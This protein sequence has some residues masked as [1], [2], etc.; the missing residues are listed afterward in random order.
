[1]TLKKISIRVRL[2]VL[3]ILTLIVCC[4]GLTIILNISANRMADVIE[5]TP[6]IPALE[7]NKESTA[8]TPPPISMIPLSPS[9]ESQIARTNFL[10][11][12][13]L[14]MLLVVATGGGITYFVSGK[15]LVPLRELSNQMKNRTIHNLSE[16]LPVPV[17][18]DEIADLTGSFNQM[19]NKLDEAFAMQKRFSQSAAHELRTPLT[20]LKTKV[21]VF[22][23]KKEH[24][25]DEYDKLLSVITTHTDRLAELVMDLLDLT[26]MDA[27]DCNEQI[28]LKA[29]LSDITQELAPLAWEKNIVVTVEGTEKDVPGNKSLL[30]RAFY[31]LIENAINYNTEYGEVHIR[32][33]DASGQ[34]LVTISDT[35]IGI[36]TELQELIFEPFFRVDK[37]RSR[38]MGGA[39]LGL[40]T[41]KTIIEK[42]NGSVTV[43][44]NEVGGSC[45]TIQ[46]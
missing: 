3:S 32:V 11:Q 23:K 38:Q 13:I 28:E 18:N 14:Y 6:I 43:S 30:H 34:G 22:N 12:S 17:S 24:T 2:T 7:I 31:N 20:V 35:G 15:A 29:L 5:A 44:T 36:P 9:K 4:V 46:I 10:Y 40:A 25:A 33:E 27:L 19:S 39:G 8:Q 37:S 45:F 41:V 42:H 16:D 21:D 1:M 26:N